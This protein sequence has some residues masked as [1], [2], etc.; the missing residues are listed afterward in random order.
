VQVV[1]LLGAGGSDEKELPHGHRKPP[2]S[3]HGRNSSAGAS[4]TPRPRKVSS[5]PP[6]GMRPPASEPVHPRP[7]GPK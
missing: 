5:R 1:E 4:N 6:P 7:R 3:A 2:E